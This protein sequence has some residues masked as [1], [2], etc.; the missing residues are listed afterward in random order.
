MGV[1]EQALSYLNAPDDKK[2]EILNSLDKKIVDYTNEKSIKKTFDSG[3]TMEE[4]KKMDSAIKEVISFLDGM[5]II[6]CLFPK[7]LADKLLV[8]WRKK[9]ME[10]E[11]EFVRE[12]F[13]KVYDFTEELNTA[14]FEGRVSD[15]DIRKIVGEIKG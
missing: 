6:A 15:G 10:I 5:K 8:G 11:N 3:F 1:G 12:W 13:R 14:V 2:E 4:A 7:E 9:N